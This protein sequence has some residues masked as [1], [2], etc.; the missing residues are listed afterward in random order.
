VEVTV[1]RPGGPSNVHDADVLT[2]PSIICPVCG[3][4]WS[5]DLEVAVATVLDAPSR[6]AHAFAGRDGPRHMI[7]GTLSPREQ[8]WY[9]VDVLRY[10]TE[11]LWTLKL[12]PDAG[13]MPWHPRDASILRQASPM[14][15]RVGLWALSVAAGDWSR[16]ARDAP[17]D[18]S[19]WHDDLGWMSRMLMIRRD[20]HE[21]VHRELE[22]RDT[23]GP[24]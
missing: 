4:D 6:Y 18:I 13:V 21:V 2:A 23:L 12:D 15:V 10:G 14:S 8:L 9:V 17:A 5:V 24:A 20:T 7:D 1:R 3:F 22:I 16:A 19:A 11:R